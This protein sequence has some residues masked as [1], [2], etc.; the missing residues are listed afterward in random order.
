MNTILDPIPVSLIN[1]RIRKQT[2]MQ[3]RKFIRNSGMIAV[4]IGAFGHISWDKEKFVGDTNT[5]TD[6][7]GPFY[8]PNAPLRVNIN[9]PGYS[10]EVF[11]LSGTV[12]RQDG[13]TPFANSLVEIWQAD[14]VKGY[15]NISDTFWY[16]GSQRVGKNGKYHF[17]TAMPKAYPI[18]PGSDIHR[19]AHI[20][21]RI[22][23]EGQQDLITQIYF[24]DDPLLEKDP[25]TR[26]PEAINRILEIKTNGKNE[27]MVQFDVVMQKEFKPAPEVYKKLSGIYEMNDDSLIEFYKDG[28]MLMV[29]RNGQIVEGLSYTGTNTFVGGAKGTS[30][31]RAVFELQEGGA[32]KV[33]IDHYNAYSKKEGKT[34][35]VKAFRY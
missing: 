8:R 14:D 20:H 26:S 5:T 27:T 33:K 30:T 15:D 22:S 32:V 34:E 16:R 1:S 7:L 21:M 9:P 13:K 25:S 2:T 3:R 35:G 28:D 17:I 19:P 12:F 24:K 23:G 18:F 29:K 31:T 11:H 4:G 6:I 10:G